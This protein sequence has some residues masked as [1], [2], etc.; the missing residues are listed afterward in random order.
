MDQI[1]G[2]IRLV[3]ILG[4]CVPWIQYREQGCVPYS[5]ASQWRFEGKYQFLID[6]ASDS[7]FKI[8]IRVNCAKVQ[9]EYLESLLRESKKEEAVPVLHDDAVNDLIFTG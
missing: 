9:K 6:F 5:G 4:Q 3:V 1:R 8:G 7:G 2:Q